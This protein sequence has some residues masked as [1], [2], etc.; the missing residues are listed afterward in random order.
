[1]TDKDKQDK[2]L[3]SEGGRLERKSWRAWARRRI[4]KPITAEDVLNNAL[5]RQARYDKKPG[6]L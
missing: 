6:G 5:S 3:K 2:A 1:M 4:G